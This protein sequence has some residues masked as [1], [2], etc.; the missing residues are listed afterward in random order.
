MQ[1]LVGGQINV[2]MSDLASAGQFMKTGKVRPIAST[3]AV[4]LEQAPQVPTIAESGIS[5]F[6]A[7]AWQGFA[8]PAGTPQAVIAALNGAYAKAAAN[9]AV[10]QRLADLGGEVISSSSDTMAAHMRQ[11][12][13]V[14]AQ[15]IRTSGI[16]LD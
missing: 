10:K 12:A 16:S 8:A 14:W 2:L 5:G 6:D 3:G 1:D 7:W 15:I 13:Q 9:P 4:R 11:E